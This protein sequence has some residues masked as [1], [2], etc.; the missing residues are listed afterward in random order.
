MVKR[1]RR[2]LAAH[3]RPIRMLLLDVDGVMTDGGLY[4]SADGLEQK[5]FHAHDGYG[6]VLAHR[7][8]LKVGIISGRSTPVVTARAAALNIED[9][10]QGTEDKVTAMRSIQQK[11]GFVDEEFAF[12]GDELFDIPL[13]QIVGFS[14]APRNARREVKSVVDYVTSVDGGDGAVRE[15]VEVILKAQ[16][17]LGN[18]KSG[19]TV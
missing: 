1:S 8:G 15:V 11:Y 2:T 17:P 3:L 14:A 12:V 4:Y 9:V 5:R 18:R 16:T 10:F 6:I 13:L 7:H 19:T